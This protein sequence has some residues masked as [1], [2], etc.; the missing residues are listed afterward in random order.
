MEDTDKRYSCELEQYTDTYMNRTITANGNYLCVQ[1]SEHPV[2]VYKR[3]QPDE[4]IHPFTDQIEHEGTA[5][6][7]EYIVDEKEHATP[8]R[9]Q[10]L[11][12]D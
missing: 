1:W 6:R 2:H 5:Y 8:R 12:S 9:E 7:L 11:Y 3:V 10:V 4:Q